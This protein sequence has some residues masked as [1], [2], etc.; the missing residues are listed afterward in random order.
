[1][2]VNNNALKYRYKI[3]I[4]WLPSKEPHK[5]LGVTMHIIS[6]NSKW[7]FLWQLVKL[8]SVSK[9]NWKCQVSW[10][11]QLHIRVWLWM[12]LKMHFRYNM[13]V[14]LDAIKIN[15]RCNHLSV[16]Y[17]CLIWSITWHLESTEHNSLLSNPL[18]PSNIYS[19]RSKPY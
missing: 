10:S 15:A 5:L 2:M 11:V 9:G 14:M 19:L 1:M 17:C 3:W 4:R 13:R 12:Q 16:T 8:Q 18:S 6:D 7:W